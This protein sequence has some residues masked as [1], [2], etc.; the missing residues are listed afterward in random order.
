MF[1]RSAVASV[2]GIGA[3]AGAVGGV[4]VQKTTGYVLTWTHSY[5]L[6][7][8]FCGSAYLVALAIMHLLSPRLAPAKLD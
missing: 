4:L 8:L 1:P 7:F 3:A 2:V 6:M 5:F